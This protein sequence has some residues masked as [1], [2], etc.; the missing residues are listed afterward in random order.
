MAIVRQITLLPETKLTIT[1]DA[2][3]YGRYVQLPVRSG[4]EQ[5]YSPISIGPNQV[6]EL[7]PFND[8]RKY[9]ITSVSGEITSTQ[10]FQGVD[11]L[12]TEAVINALSSATLELVIPQNNDQVLIKDSSDS[13]KLK[14]VTVQSLV[15][16]VGASSSSSVSEPVNQ[17]SHGLTVLDVVRLNSS[18]S[19]VKSIA[20]S[21]QNA[22]VIGIV[23][24]ILDSDNFTLTTFGKVSGFTGLVP[25]DVYFLSES[26][27]G[28]VTTTPPSLFIEGNVI[29]PVLVAESATT[30]Y[31]KN[32]VGHAID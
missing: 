17:A 15:D 32:Y 13:G 30:A 1:C 16:L 10:V 6:I 7:G 3:S 26:V 4:D 25:G 8:T 12:S 19:F 31:F 24:E 20:N 9:K 28:A 5:I 23:T 14:A 29:K 21:T 18:G 27:A 2:V 22:E 11:S